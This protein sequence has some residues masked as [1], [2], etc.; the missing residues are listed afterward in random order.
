MEK[1]GSTE[2]N[3][4]IVESCLVQPWLCSPRETLYLSNLDNQ[5]LVRMNFNTLLVYDGSENVL[6]HPAKTIRE[7]LNERQ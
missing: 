3:V 5:P 2:L 1:A 4:R 7:A 6:P